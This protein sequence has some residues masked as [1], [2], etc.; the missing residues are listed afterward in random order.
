MSYTKVMYQRPTTTRD[1]ISIR[2]THPAPLKPKSSRSETISKLKA[3]YS[4]A[5]R[6]FLHHKIEEANGLVEEAF[7]LLYP[8]ASHESDPLTTHRRK[9][10]ILRITLE[11]TLYTT[12]VNG[13]V[14]SKLSY[15]STNGSSSGAIPRS[16]NGS[17]RSKSP[18][19][20]PLLLSPPSLLGTLHTRSL[21]LFT[22][23][24]ERPNSRFL[25]AAVLV[26]LV[27]ASLKLDCPQVGRGMVDDWL[28]NRDSLGLGSEADS[29]RGTKAAD[30]REG[31]QKLVEVYCLHVLPRLNEWDYAKDFLD[32]EMEM[33][34]SKRE[35]LIATLAAHHTQSLLP[36]SPRVNQLQNLDNSV[37][38]SSGAPTP[39]AVSPAPSS[40]SSHTAVPNSRSVATLRASQVLPSPLSSSPT[41][42]A[43]QWQPTIRTSHHVPTS[44]GIPPPAPTLAPQSSSPAQPTTLQLLKAVIIPY[45]RRINA[46]VL[47]LAIVLSF[48]GLASR[49]GRR[50]KDGSGA[51][52]ARRRLAGSSGGIWA[53]LVDAVKM[54]GRGLV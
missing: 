42:T 45:L 38:G 49:F 51:E 1:A 3:T 7:E 6:A 17:P 5:A 9:W 44:L 15:S 11:T 13:S 19:N 16:P 8:P 36:P 33:R 39:R 2:T 53:G 32:S 43:R 54:S 48:I 25:P 28:A 34:P 40:V 21:K 35:E 22:P 50:P 4:H 46:P 10:D 37:S 41:P 26:A 24:L 30:E 47:L 29:R 20:D 27:L 14:P 18:L 52:M 31:Y 12:P 23:A